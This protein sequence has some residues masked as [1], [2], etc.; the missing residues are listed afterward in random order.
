ML[1]FILQEYC[2]F[3]KIR[4]GNAMGKS[5]LKQS[6]TEKQNVIFVTWMVK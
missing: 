1:V 2:I 6:I 5:I 3:D 4:I